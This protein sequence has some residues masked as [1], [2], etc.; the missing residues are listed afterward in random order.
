MNVWHEGTASRDAE[1]I[2]FCLLTYITAIEDISILTLSTFSDSCGGQNRNI[3]VAMMWM[4]ITQTAS[5]QKI[6]HKFMTSGHSYLPNDA[7]FGIIERSKP[8]S[9]ELFVPQQW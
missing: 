6:D 4:Y 8:K 1:K 5:I 9:T 3:K 7:D 2:G